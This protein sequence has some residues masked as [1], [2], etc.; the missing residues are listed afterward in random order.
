[1]GNEQESTAEN[2]QSVKYARATLAKEKELSCTTDSYQ[3]MRTVTTTRYRGDITLVY[4]PRNA[5]EGR[6]TTQI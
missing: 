2:L 3:R 1:M 6:V 4:S 5:S